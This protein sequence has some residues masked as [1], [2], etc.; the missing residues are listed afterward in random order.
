PPHITKGCEI[1]RRSTYRRALPNSIPRQTFIKIGKDYNMKLSVHS[2]IFPDQKEFLNARSL[3]EIRELGYEGLELVPV[4]W[5]RKE[6]ERLKGQ[7]DDLG[8]TVILGWSLG[9][10]ENPLSEDVH[11]RERAKEQMKRLID[12]A[13]ILEA[14]ILAG[15]NYA[16]AGYTTGKP[17]T[18]RE[19]DLAVKAYRKICEYSNS[20]SGP[21]LCLE[22]AVRADSHLI[23]T[24]QRAKEFV[25]AVD[26]PK[27]L[28]LLDTYQMLREED[29][30][31]AAIRD[32]EGYIGYFHVSESH[33][34]IPGRGTIPWRRVFQM[35]KE[36]N[37]QGW[38]GVEAFWSSDLPVASRA[39][40]WRCLA[41]SPWMLLREAA[42]FIATNYFSK[43]S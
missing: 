34:G 14:P 1:R 4:G 43:E 26:S 29:S 30:F 10:D 25:R 7:A 9:M 18:P 16:A 23:N 17:S 38:L 6:I 3:G 41:D 28:I 40:I 39:K 32:A 13:L 31:E 36:L 21:T 33:R 37:Y 11:V 35:L 8:M 12:Y 20:H 2:L 42:E 19:W 15:L 22:P 24:V 5:D 27:A